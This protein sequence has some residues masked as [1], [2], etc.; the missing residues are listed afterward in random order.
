MR[1][2]WSPPVLGAA[3]GSISL[4]L[5]VASGADA[6][7][8]HVSTT[9]QVVISTPTPETTFVTP[10]DGRLRGQDFAAT[11]TGVAWPDHTLIDGKDELATPGHRFVDF[12]LQLTED[13]S[14]IAPTGSDPGVTA[15]VQWGQSS[16]SLSLAAIDA[17]IANQASET[18]W[19]SGS[20]TYVVSVP[21][22]DHQVDLAI[23]QGSF[24][25][26]FNLWTLQ[27]NGPAPTVL[28]RDTSRPTISESAPASTTLSM[29]NPSDG[30]SSTAELSLSSATL[31]YWAPTVGSGAVILPDQAILSVVIQSNHPIDENN[32]AAT[33]HYLGADSPLSGTLLTF[34]P[35]GAA[36]I[37]ATMSDSGD[38]TGQS[39]NDDG[40]FDALYSF[41]VPATLTTG[42]LT[43]G[44]GSFTGVEVVDD[45]PEGGNMTLDIPTPA[46][47]A[48]GFPALAVAAPQKRPPWVGAPLPPTVAASSSTVGTSAGNG[49]GF[50]IWL[51]VALL[52]ALAAAVVAV[53][54][55]YRHRR[56][57]AGGPSNSDAGTKTPP[58]EPTAAAEPVGT[59][60]QV[61]HAAPTAAGAS[62]GA[63]IPE[64]TP[65]PSAVPPVASAPS[66]AAPA[67]PA[68]APA[69]SEL[70]MNV[71]GPPEAH[72]YRQVPERRII[73]ELLCFL[74]LHDRHP[75][76]ADQIQLAI[77]P[78]GGQRP[79]VT[80]QTFHSYISG[81]RQC[82]GAEH[83][84]DA[85]N[86]AGYRI[87][88]VECDW[89]TFQRLS[90][91]ADTTVG[92]TSI[93]LRTQA[94]SLVRG[95]PF[96]GVA[97]GQYEW[98][99]NED[100]HT[101]MSAAV[102]TCALRLANDLFTLG[103]YSAVE[104]AARAGLRGS[105]ED[106]HLKRVRDRAIE[107]RN[108]G[109]VRSGP[110][111]GDS[112]RKDGAPGDSAPGDPVSLDPEETGQEG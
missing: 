1:P 61:V 48:V 12:N 68:T 28:Y 7:V 27:R 76:N 69:A 67:D 70:A 99:F 58:T 63:D 64:P 19:P 93:A 14:A 110:A 94:L 111:L 81:L 54:R 79:E 112:A 75:L 34:T 40:L 87:N 11:V 56:L 37:T 38:T 77:W 49:S 83:L 32:A 102:V 17:E 106:I 62:A 92:P 8:C 43:I 88:G 5:G 57:L 95:E 96:E 74:V 90:D 86:F 46:T 53:Q 108:D 71:L 47:M 84:P 30:F 29:T 42:T 22:R 73:E 45:A 9:D 20:A 51:A 24:S 104:D 35:A 80:R 16:D 50:P 52:V 2:F 55:L 109:L 72:G 100:L 18:T 60:Q 66:A 36:P 103:R 39:N 3:V 44:P 25:Q 65:A 91:Q 82:I 97:R 107:A 23:F 13:A 105:P 98:A 59:A 31:S 89:F 4:L 78:T 6:S 26:T 15:A 33:G 101:Q 21:S 41:V 85:T 10:S